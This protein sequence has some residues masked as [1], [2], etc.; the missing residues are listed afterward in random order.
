MS[1]AKLLKMRLGEPDE[2]GRRRPFPIEGSQLTVPVDTVV[3][4]IGQITSPM[5]ANTTP[6]L[7]THPKWGTVLVNEKTAATTKPGV[8]AGG[9]AT[10]GAATV[11]LAAGAGR[12]AAKHI[13]YYL[14]NKNKQGIWKKLWGESVLQA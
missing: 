4:A 9:D 12:N 10:T 7:E 11:I 1:K 14:Q 3:V 8:F 6:G 13:D 5:I 2:S